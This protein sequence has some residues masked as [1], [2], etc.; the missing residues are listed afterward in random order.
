MSQH[1][2]WLQ[3]IQSM[4]TVPDL[5]HSNSVTPNEK[6]HHSLPLE[7]QQIRQQLAHMLMCLQTKQLSA[8][9]S[10]TQKTETNTSPMSSH[11]PNTFPMSR[12]HKIE[13]NTSPMSLNHRPNTSPMSQNHKTETNTVLL[14]QNQRPNTSPMSHDRPNTSSMSQNHNIET[15]TSPISQ[16]VETNTFPKSSD[17]P[18]TSPMSSDR[19]N[20]CPMSL[21]D[22]CENTDTSTVTGIS[23]NTMLSMLSTVLRPHSAPNTLLT[24]HNNLF[25]NGSFMEDN[26]VGDTVTSSDR[27]VHFAVHDTQYIDV[28]KAVPRLTP[29]QLTVS[30]QVKLPSY[31]SSFCRF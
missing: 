10:P 22:H 15:N 31:I 25:T 9:L 12:N 1:Q 14:S 3:Q 27:S 19:P 13:T 4:P 6:Y 23:T 24:D 2:T 17:R 28:H 5:D 21:S 16:K 18:N 7:A 11:R 8:S 26:T 30:D 29:Y 20:T